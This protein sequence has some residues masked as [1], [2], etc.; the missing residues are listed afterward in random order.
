ML[1]EFVSTGKVDLDGLE[2]AFNPS[3]GP[4]A[5]DNKSE[6]LLVSNNLK[7]P[8]AAVLTCCPMQLVLE[9]MHNYIDIEHKL[10]SHCQ[11]AI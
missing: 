2:D 5:L 6:Q 11:A 7:G 8:P 4:A 1:T 10:P 3:Q 9:H